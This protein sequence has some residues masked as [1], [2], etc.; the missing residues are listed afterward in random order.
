MLMPLTASFVARVC[1]VVT[2]NEPTC[3]QRPVF[4]FASNTSLTV[5]NDLLC[6]CQL[7]VPRAGRQI[8]NK[9]IEAPPINFMK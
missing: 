6:N 7:C 4:G 9:N 8:Q 1:G 5:Q 3:R 2:I